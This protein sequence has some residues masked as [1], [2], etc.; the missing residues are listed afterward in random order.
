M[1]KSRKR[2]HNLP[3]LRKDLLMITTATLGFP[4]IGPNRELKRAQEAFWSGSLNAAAFR[5]AAKRIRAER[6]QRQHQA[7]ISVIPSNDFTLY[8]HILDTCCLLGAVPERFGD[9]SVPVD[10]DT[11]FRMARGAK[12]VP[13]LEMTKWFD[14]NYHY[15]VPE[16][17]AST[18]F[19]AHPEKL[20]EEYHAAREL[21]ITTRPVLVGPL[22]F[23]RLAKRTDGGDPLDLLPQL[24]P[25]YQQILTTLAEAGV[26]WV[27]IDEPILVCDG[28]AALQQALS[29]AY[30]TLREG[31]RPRLLL[32]TYFGRLAENLDTVCSLPID[33]LHLDLVRAPEQVAALADRWPSDRFLSL[34]L[35]DGRNIWRADLE[36]VLASA[37]AVLAWHPAEL[38][39]IASS[40]SLLH[41][42]VD[43]AGE[44]NLSAEVR[45]WLAFATQKCAELHTVASALNAGEHSVATD[46]AIAAS[47]L[48]SRRASPQTLVPAVRDRCRQTNEKHG[49]RQS[50]R[51]QRLAAQAQHL[52]LPE[53]PTTTI[54]SFPQT[55][56]V[57]RQRRALRDGRIDQAAYEAFLEKEIAACIRRQEDLGLDVLVHG[58]FERNDMVEYFGEL[59]NGYVFTGGGWVQSYGSRCV[60]P[61]IIVGDISRPAPMTVRWATYAQS[62]TQKAV[63]GML[64]GPVT[65]LNWSFVRNDISRSEV[66]QQLAWALRDEVVD[67]EAAGIAIIQIDEP[68]LREGLPLRSCDRPA[69][70]DWAIRAFRIT[71]AGVRDKTQIHTHMCYSEFNDI[72]GPIAD[73][74]ADVITIETSRS[75][76]ELLNAFEEVGYPGAI[77]PGVYDVH[78]PAVPSTDQMVNLLRRASRSLPRERIWVNPDCGLKT[79]GWPEVDA[80]LRNMLTAA[81]QMR[82]HLPSPG[83]RG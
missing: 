4:R 74:D 40:C 46:L 76:M 52:A 50:P 10:L 56:E 9:G 77:G 64:T 6:W 78:S 19:T 83:F 71:A 11:Y 63:K 32:T 79:R 80:A 58:E 53:Y 60:K 44:R 54:G 2:S 61:P 62:L 28:D 75:H 27:Q 37:R 24:L 43:L 49:L 22:T 1:I 68:A 72:I 3:V 8:D 23:L 15:L 20:L 29:T 48:A 81:Q 33:G 21:D 47:A 67:L 36:A 39:Q 59:L 26:E 17:E 18:H 25:V 16:L 82:G 35:I 38:L 5:E 13:A 73:M 12:G 30:Q 31:H 41:V 57:R 34:G 42:P 51:D 7:G 55:A 70:M 14:T 45:S 65:M 69:Y 66:C